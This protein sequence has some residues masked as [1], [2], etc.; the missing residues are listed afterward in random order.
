[1]VTRLVTPATPRLPSS[2]QEAEVWDRRFTDEYSRILGL[3]FRQLDAVNA[4]LL[5]TR[6]GRYLDNPY[7]AFSNT[8]TQALT[9]AN[10]PYVVS[11]NTTD[12][13]NGTSLATNQITVAQTGLYNVQFSLQ[14]ENTAAQ[15]TEVWV[16]LRTN[17][18][19]V[20]D[21]ASIWAVTSTHGSVNGYTLGACNFYIALNAGDYLELVAAANATG[22][23]I[24]SYTSSTSPFTRP[25]IPGAVVTVS[26]V[27]AVP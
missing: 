3:Y 16:W 13:A 23:N 18:V 22:M 9:A 27:S 21:T 14:F 19:D 1:M 15:I 4:S 12:H 24:E 20:P 5:G 2:P 8:T 11:L 7:G 6:G 25:S 10:T 26:F 17:G